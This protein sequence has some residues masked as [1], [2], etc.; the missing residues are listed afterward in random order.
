MKAIKKEAFA[1]Y[2]GD[3]QG[4]PVGEPL[5]VYPFLAACE[6]SK[7]Y[8]EQ[9]GYG[10]ISKISL[11]QFEDVSYA[12]S[13]EHSNKVIVGSMPEATPVFVYKDY[14]YENSHN[15]SKYIYGDDELIKLL[16]DQK[17]HE[18]VKQLAIR[19][20][21]NLYIL[22]SASPITV[23]SF[24]LSREMAVKNAL[25]KLSNEEKSLLGLK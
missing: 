4:Y 18:I 2:R 25:G 3:G 9:K 15:L 7:A 22:E 21:A 5:S 14:V 17:S 23:K 19:D 13:S 10:V 6:F 24:T 12:S 20:E 1:V 8:T 11:I 16:D